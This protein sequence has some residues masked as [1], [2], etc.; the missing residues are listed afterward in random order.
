MP[1][2]FS[3]RAASTASRPWARVGVTGVFSSSMAPRVRTRR[4]VSFP[5][6]NRVRVS[7]PEQVGGGPCG[8]VR[9]QRRRGA[10]QR[11]GSRGVAARR[12]GDLRD[13]QPFVVGQCASG[14]QPGAG[15]RGQQVG[16]SRGARHAAGHLG[17]VGQGDDQAGGVL[18][19][20]HALAL[21][22]AG[23]VPAPARSTSRCSL[24]DSCFQALACGWVPRCRDLSS[25]PR[26]AACAR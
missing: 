1:S 15:S 8:G 16:G 19:G 20:G 24:A 18:A 10:D 25:S 11:P 13:G 12:A 4:A 3:R 9:I 17:G 21:A 2:P 5:A 14:R 7:S 23:A 22:V 26:S 6:A